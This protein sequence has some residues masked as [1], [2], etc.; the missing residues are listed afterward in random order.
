MPGFSFSRTLVSLETDTPPSPYTLNLVLQI[1]F[2]NL[3]SAGIGRTGA[4]CSLSTAIERVQAEGMVD[5][6]HTVKHL[7]T[8]RPHMVQSV[9]CNRT[10]YYREGGGRGEGGRE[11]YYWIGLVWSVHPYYLVMGGSYDWVYFMWS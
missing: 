11:S 5:V 1:L 2:L 6:F 3:C 7:R 10:R 8:Q 9:V 4:F